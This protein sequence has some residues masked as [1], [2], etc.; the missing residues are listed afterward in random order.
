MLIVLVRPFAGLAEVC[1][2]RKNGARARVARLYIFR[3]SVRAPVT[4]M[5]DRAAF[6]RSRRTQSREGNL[7]KA[8]GGAVPGVQERERWPLIPFRLGRGTEVP[9]ALPIPLRAHWGGREYSSASPGAQHKAH[10][11]SQACAPFL[12]SRQYYGD[13]GAPH[14]GQ[15]RASMGPEERTQVSGPIHT[16]WEGLF[17]RSHARSAQR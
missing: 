15:C 3:L 17:C 9:P 11:F 12:L 1:V 13:G 6:E 5:R 14:T 10:R 8:G 2:F 7:R 4:R 16:L